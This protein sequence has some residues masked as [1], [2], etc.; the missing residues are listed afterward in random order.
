M[1]W[2]EMIKLRS[3]RTIAESGGPES[4]S[5]FEVLIME[6]FYENKIK[7]GRILWYPR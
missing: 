6:V 1:R 4:Q 2:I 5:R 7:K 3:T